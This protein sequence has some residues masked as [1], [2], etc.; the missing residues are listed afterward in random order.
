LR[1]SLS[2]QF[3]FCTLDKQQVRSI[4]GAA[5]LNPA[6]NPGNKPSG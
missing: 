1:H 3:R 2:F 5:F 6:R 4:I